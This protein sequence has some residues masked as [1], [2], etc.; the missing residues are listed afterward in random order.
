[1]K[2][3]RFYL[4]AMLT[5]L[6]FVACSDDD[7]DQPA[8][9]GVSVSVTQ[10][11]FSEGD[12]TVTVS[13]S[14]S[15]TFSTDVVVTYEVTGTAIAGEDYV[16]LPGSL[17]L[18]AGESMVTQNL[19][20]TDDDEVEANEEI[21]I[22]LTSV[23]GGSD[24]IGS[25]NAVTLTLTD[26]DSFAFENGILVLHEGGFFMGNAS[27]SF[28]S[29][30]LSMVTNGIFN[31][32][33]DNAL[34]DTAQSMAFEGDLAYIVVNNSQ[35]VEVV[36]R[37]TFES[38]GTV[39]EGLLNPRYMAFANGKGYVT[40]WGDGSNPDDDYI[41]VINLE[42]LSVESTIPVPEGPEWILNN[43]G[44]IYVA[45]QGGFGQNNIVSVIDASSNTVGDPITVADRPNSMQLVNGELWVL[46]GG[47]PAFTGNETAGQLDKINVI[48]NTVEDTFEFTQTQHPNYLSV[49][50]NSLYYL[51]DGN[52]FKMGVSDNSLP[53]NAEIMG[54]SFYDMTV[55]EGRLYGVDAKDFVSNGSLEVY[56]L[57]DNSIIESLEVS[58]I[59]GGV[60]FNANF[61]F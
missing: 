18:T 22:T 44:T 24:F 40:N 54:V 43:E 47:N 30:D 11:S 15:E 13:F 49:D 7:D 55:N 42:S 50:G 56:D 2:N 20:L 60:Y 31:D 33:N 14:T 59:P 26:N 32:I 27:V 58:I 61:E 9:P 5:G 21:I 52:V 39:D 8:L 12:G 19:V 37:Y 46:S 45:H 35:T 51:L 23:D 17:T 25:N 48:T 4:T 41:A 36:N 1:M 16:A 29:E 10:D 6:L 28:V 53:T 38:L 3:T 34:G 57:S